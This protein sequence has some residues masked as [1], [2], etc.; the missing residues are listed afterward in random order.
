MRLTLSLR[1][2]SHNTWGTTSK[3][4]T[5]CA[6]DRDEINFPGPA[7]SP[8]QLAMFAHGNQPTCR[9]PPVQLRAADAH[10]PRSLWVVL[11]PPLTV[12]L[13]RPWEPAH[14]L[15]VSSSLSSRRHTYTPV[16][17]DGTGTVQNIVPSALHAASPSTGKR[18]GCTQRLTPASD[19]GG[20]WGSGRQATSAARQ[21]RGRAGRSK[22][23]L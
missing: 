11:T 6:L 23:C 22:E 17:V 20:G 7:I 14:L 10:T 2:P 13:V 21:R 15:R 16:L 5:C 1:N 8:S 12:Y 18:H 19:C 4:L 3:R 9:A